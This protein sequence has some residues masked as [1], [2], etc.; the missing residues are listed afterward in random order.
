MRLLSLTCGPTD[1]MEVFQ[2]V[3]NTVKDSKAETH[4]L[5]LMQHLLLIRNDYM[6]R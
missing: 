5:S 1:V 3:M 6:V 2:V 4:L